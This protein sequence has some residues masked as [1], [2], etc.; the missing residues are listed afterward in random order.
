VVQR[1]RSEADTPLV[2]PAPFILP[3]AGPL[4]RHATPRILE[5]AIAPVVVFLVFLH[6]F[7]VT[8]AVAAGLGFCYS[9]LAWRLITRRPVPGLLMLGAASLT[10]RSILALSTGSVFVYFLQPTLGTALVAAVMLVSAGAGRPLVGRLAR[11]FCPIPDEV[12]AGAAVR[13]FFHQLTLLW[14]L[15][16]LSIAGIAMW[17]LLSQSVGVFVVTRTVASL[18]LTALAIG[19]S[20]VWFQRSMSDHVA[21][22]PRRVRG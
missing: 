14:A 3:R 12:A 19:L 6:F 13:R 17:L 10:V 5:G 15:T 2:D 21:F 22:A 20:I 18:S 4:L 8:G 16:E 7:A 11:D 1:G 9:L